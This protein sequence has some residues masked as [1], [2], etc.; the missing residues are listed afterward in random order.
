MPISFVKNWSDAN[1]YCNNTAINGQTGWRLPTKDELV[2]LYHSGAMKVQG[3]T[4]GYA[5]SSTPTSSSG[6]F[7]FSL[8]L[9]NVFPGNVT[10]HMSVR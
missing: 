5:Q 8:D 4:W 2:A 3:W 10:G 1:T 9:G 7:F 6:H